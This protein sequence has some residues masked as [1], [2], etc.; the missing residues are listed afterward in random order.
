MNNMEI[1][2]TENNQNQNLSH[3]LFGANL[4]TIIQIDAEQ[5]RIS[6]ELKRLSE[7]FLMPQLSQAAYH[8]FEHV[9]N[10]E[11]EIHRIADRLQRYGITVDRQAVLDANIGHDALYHLNAQALGF[12]SK[13]A[14]A[15]HYIY[16]ILL[17]LGAKETYALK[18]RQIISKTAVN[19]LPTNAEELLMRTADLAS[20]GRSYLEYKTGTDL[21][22]SESQIQSG[23]KISFAEFVKRQLKYLAHYVQY[24][25]N[26][27][28]DAY[29]ESGNSIW[30]KN[31][32]ANTLKCYEES[33][34]V[35]LK[36]YHLKDHENIKEELFKISSGANVYL[37]VS[38]NTHERRIELLKFED[39]LNCPFFV[40]PSEST[41]STK[42]GLKPIT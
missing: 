6:N 26:I 38:A 27:T 16:N 22:F 19:S 4:R 42:I 33:L 24:D 31:V 36:L 15:A 17:S 32:I 34:Q 40:I 20:I 3:G 7:Q 10:N 25:L 5:M 14:L 28:P 2:I 21:L 30:H 1:K 9:K 13:E 37:V 41:P 12:D 29:D 18:V 35:P 39:Q 23:K 11:K 8:V